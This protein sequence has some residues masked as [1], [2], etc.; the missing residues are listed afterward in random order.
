M[1]VDGGAARDNP[2]VGRRLA[3][4]ATV[5]IAVSVVHTA[6]VF[7]EAFHF[8]TLFLVL[9]NVL[10]ALAVGSVAGLDSALLLLTSLAQQCAQRGDF[11]FKFC[12]RI[13]VGCDCL[14][15]LFILVLPCIEVGV[16]AIAIV[17]EVGNLG[18]EEGQL[19]LET[20]NLRRQ[21]S[22]LDARVFALAV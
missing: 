4:T 5:C 20:G 18:L 8:A 19:F 9:G 3:Y 13:L 6:G 12:R 22:L 21:M 11:E 16:C 7:F 15:D 2:C 1:I 10:V 17:L 14:G